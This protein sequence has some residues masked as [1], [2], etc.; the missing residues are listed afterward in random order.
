[1]IKGKGAMDNYWKCY[2]RDASGDY[3][4]VKHTNK[5][6]IKPDSI[7]D[8]DKPFGVN[9]ISNMLHVLCGCRPVSSL[10]QSIYKRVSAI[11]EVAKEC[12]FRIDNRYRYKTTF[13]DKNTGEIGENHK[14]FTEW[15]HGRQ[16]I[17][18]SNRNDLYTVSSTRVVFS[19]AYVTW[20]YFDKKY[21]KD[22]RPDSVK[23]YTE[24]IKTFEECAG[25]SYD[26]LKRKFTF[27]DFLIWCG[28]D[29]EK[30]DK[31]I[32]V[33]NKGLK[34]MLL[35][36]IIDVLSSCNSHMEFL[37]KIDEYERYF[38]ELFGNNNKYVYALKDS[39]TYEK[40]KDTLKDYLT[41]NIKSLDFNQSK[42]AGTPIEVQNI[43]VN[44]ITV[45]KKCPLNITVYVPM[46][47]DIVTDAILSG[48]RVATF[49]ENGMAEV[50][51]SDL[52]MDDVMF[53]NRK[54]KKVVSI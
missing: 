37:V 12:W 6:V 14:F 5:R 13:I 8:I 34:P 10:Y 39:E 16:S 33:L 20:S 25:C 48:T 54:F 17:N 21:K 52:L 15:G 32:M 47:D 22:T 2:E 11:D 18:N 38:E 50:I 36:F 53:E 24:H 1:M 3:G 9:H 28:R 31:M 49:L 29:S 19:K 35:Y 23:K 4:W 44:N 43:L 42:P 41:N 40:K 7:E 46:D 27:V 26:E 30:R 51:D 45:I